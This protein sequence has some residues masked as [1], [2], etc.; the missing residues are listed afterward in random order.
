MVEVVTVGNLQLRVC[1]VSGP[2]PAV[3]PGERSPVRSGKT[4]A[5]AAA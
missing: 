2:V 3:R 4:E 5:V 1:V